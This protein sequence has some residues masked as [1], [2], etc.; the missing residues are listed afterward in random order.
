MI[1]KLQRLQHTMKDKLPNLDECERQLCYRF[2]DINLLRQALTHSSCAISHIESNER[3][4]FLG[5]AV[6]GLVIS[7]MLYTHFPRLQ[8]GD[9]SRIKSVIV[10][11]KKC[12]KVATRLK[13]KDFLFVGRAINAVPD[14]LVANVMES[15]IG[16]VFLD[17]GYEEASR[18]IEEHFFQELRPFLNL[19]DAEEG[20][21]SFYDPDGRPIE[22]EQELL[23]DCLDDNYKAKLQTIIQRERPSE[24]PQYLLLDEKGAPHC[25]CFKIAVRIG[26]R[27]FQAAW[28]KNK[29][30]TEQRAAQNALFQLQGL[31]PPHSDGNQD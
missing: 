24:T 30:E 21:S 29:K 6:L 19:N 28:G 10:S 9:L 2:N 11:R 4:E 18:F 3:L 13:L 12:K 27:D 26:N 1:V 23:V 17:G 22:L 15:I 16:A 8:E 25:R 7:N 31:E 20:S 5:D 14:S